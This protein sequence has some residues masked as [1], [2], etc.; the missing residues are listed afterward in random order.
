MS[1]LGYLR[2]ELPKRLLDVGISAV[3][4]LLALGV[5]SWIGDM[6][7]QGTYQA[8]L[9]AMRAEAR[10]NENV[11]NNSYDNFM[12][13]ARTYTDFSVVVA[14]QSLSNP[15]FVSHLKANDLEAINPYI[16][17]LVEANTFRA[18]DALIPSHGNKDQ[19]WQRKAIRLLANEFKEDTRKDIRSVESLH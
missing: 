9:E 8:M 19:E 18:T 10:A 14:T 5:N 3:G 4:F 13:G 17:R 7:D 11:L 1:A 12:K 6:H 15:I 16:R 2:T